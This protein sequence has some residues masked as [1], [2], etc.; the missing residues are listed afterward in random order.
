MENNGINRIDTTQFYPHITP[1]R[2]PIGDS[3]FTDIRETGRIYVDKTAILYQLVDEGKYYFLS[4]PR[5]FG[6]SLMLSTLKAYFE[7]RKELFDGLAMGRLETEWRRYPVISISMGH[8]DITSL[9]ILNNYL[10]TEVDR[11][12]RFLGIEVSG[13]TPATRFTDLIIK[14]AEKF[15]SK[16]VI[17]ID[18]YDKHMLDT[19]HRDAT[20]HEGVKSVL[21]GFYGCIKEA[22]DH[23]RFTMITGIT[24]FSHVNIFSGLNNLRDISLEVSYNAICGIAESEMAEYFSED[25]A[26]FAQRNGMTPE[27]VK[28]EI[29]FRYDGYRFAKQGE[30]IYN[31]FST[32]NAFA[33]ME[34]GD[35]WFQSGTSRYLVEELQR[36]HY[37]FSNLDGVTADEYELSG[38][39]EV[40]D[41]PVGL[42]YQSG[43]LTI[44]DYEYGTYILGFPNREVS[45][46]FYHELLRIILPQN[47]DRFSALSLYR[48]A[49]LGQPEK[50]MQQLQLGLSKFNCM[51]IQKPEYEYQ[52]KTMLH[53]IVM[54]SG[55]DVESDVLTPAGRIDMVFR[56]CRFIYLIE[57]K[58][59]STPEAA[60]QQI[61][62]KDYPFKYYGDPRP[63]FKIGANFSTEL[64]K[65]TGWII[66][67][68]Q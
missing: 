31:P 48:F 35:Y 60:L 43:Y 68:N 10:I 67:P 5:R 36:N 65:L 59:D 21:R 29:K 61:D 2:Y 52:F 15:D 11:N 27:D 66:E 42:L 22:A 24:K 13:S 16:T 33:K 49:N 25:I 55:L 26:V 14:A 41:N 19:R 44:K 12:A 30:N 58:I 54:A 53:A 47:G 46:G 32:L 23:I 9:S 40:T 18:E 56:T 64:R 62:S 51:Q 63:I 57:F 6:K 1:K 28:K 34:F 8:D 20:L 39:P 38:T 3:S 45:S 17:L 4:R 37:D 7:G 50:L